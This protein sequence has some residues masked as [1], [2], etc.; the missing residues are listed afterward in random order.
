M[1]DD[2]TEWAHWAQNAYCAYYESTGGRAHDGRPMPAWDA[3]AEETRRAWCA[4]A[5][6]ARGDD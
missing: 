4:A 3:L 2:V 6:A 1:T 5:R